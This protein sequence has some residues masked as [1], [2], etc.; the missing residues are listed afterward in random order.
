MD[1][2]HSTNHAIPTGCEKRITHCVLGTPPDNRMS[3][4]HR[5]RDTIKWFRFF[6]QVYFL[7]KAYASIS[8]YNR[9]RNEK[10]PRCHEGKYE[11]VG[12]AGLEPGPSPICAS[13]TSG[14][15]IG[16]THTQ[17]RGKKKQEEERKSD[18]IARVLKDKETPLMVHSYTLHV[19]H[20][21]EGSVVVCFVM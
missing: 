3:R 19:D 11:Q 8:D 10:K 6:F 15:S 14:K 17:R 4:I 18:K 2:I 21:G 16:S 1:C 20:V 9:A 7:G 13:N 12:E 5:D